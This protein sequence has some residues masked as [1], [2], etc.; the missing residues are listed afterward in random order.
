MIVS[1][2]NMK[3]HQKCEVKFYFDVKL[4]LR[5]KA[6]PEPVEKGLFGHDLM[7]EFFKARL[8]GM[9]YDE[10]AS[11]VTKYLGD[12]I[13][14]DSTNLVLL[15]SSRVLKHV[16]AFGAYVDN[17]PW[18][19]LDVES[20]SNWPIDDDAEF[21]FTPDLILEWT[22]GPQRGL[23]FVLDYKFTGQY[24]N[25]RQINTVQ[26]MIKYLIYYNKIHGTKMRHAGIVMLNTRADSN[27]KGNQL[28]LLKWLP[29]TKEKLQNIERENEILVKRLEPFFHM[30][31]DEYKAQ[32][33][34]T[35]D[36]LACKT[37]WYADD[38]CPMD[39]NGQDITKTV[40]ANY[41]KNDYGYN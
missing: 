13:T 38:I 14:A 37:C 22:S 1:H 40:K 27:A 8:Q 11:H 31:P 3:S 28:F 29:V 25:E 30:T 5:P 7:E 16:L 20:N 39:L 4:S 18:R 36:E 34:R 2:S 10:A 17:Q 19:I 9:S 24:W 26:Q 35:T 23:P 6:W 33:V 41:I 21:G 15:D 12:R 32:A